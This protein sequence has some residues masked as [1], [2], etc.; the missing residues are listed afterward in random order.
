MNAKP[1]MTMHEIGQKARLA[2]SLL[3]AS[4]L[5]LACGATPTGLD[6]NATQVAAE[7]ESTRTEAAPSIAP[8]AT[9][10]PT[11]T[12]VPPPTVTRTPA[13]SPTP[14]RTPRPSPTPV[15]LPS[16]SDLNLEPP[17]I[18][19]ALLPEGVVAGP[20]RNDL[21]DSHLINWALPR[22]EYFLVQ[23]LKREGR[24][25]RL[26]AMFVSVYV[27]D[28]PATAHGA[29]E[30]LQIGFGLP[31]EHVLVGIDHP[32]GIEWTRSTLV[33]SELAVVHCRTVGHI[34]L[35]T[36]DWSSLMLMMYSLL[37]RVGGVVSCLPAT[38]AA[39][40]S[41]TTTPGPAA[42]PPADPAQRQARWLVPFGSASALSYACL[43]VPQVADKY[44][45]GKIPDSDLLKEL[46]GA[47][48][49]AALSGREL[50][51]WDP[52][53]E[54]AGLRDTLLSQVNRL[55]AANAKFLADKEPMGYSYQ[56]SQLC[57]SVWETFSTVWDTAKADGLNTQDFY[58]IIDGFA[59]ALQ[60]GSDSP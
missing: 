13:P 20:I 23:E 54:D 38:D 32:S 14:T 53:Q 51:T 59:E 57:D 52:G 4:S 21:Y 47:T 50:E 3:L 2:C 45:A 36:P 35:D 58:A 41:P 29:L 26:P 42:T 11:H 43:A 44:H 25:D 49:A 33:K 1:R 8:S 46:A 16:S 56:L 5:L 30:S 60:S 22:T 24:S 48:L 28:T 15:I 37:D 6:G 55:N 10:L 18:E 19:P 12:S 7:N 39:V 27:F 31:E 17:L 34:Y 40:V 9:S